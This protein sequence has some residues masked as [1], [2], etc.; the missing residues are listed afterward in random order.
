MFPGDPMHD[1]RSSILSGPAERPATPVAAKKGKPAANLGGLT[2]IAV[3][4]QEARITNQ[5]CEDRLR[6]IVEETVM[7]FRRK[8][9]DVRVVNVS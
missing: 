5:R 4:R 6:D 7:V 2:A 1:F 8:K 9:M 3:K